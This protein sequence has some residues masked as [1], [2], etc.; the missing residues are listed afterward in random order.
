MASKRQPGWKLYDH[1]DSKYV[2]EI[3][4]LLTVRHFRLFVES[5]CHPS[6]F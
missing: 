5:V 2:L 3:R 6:L 4:I 1:Y